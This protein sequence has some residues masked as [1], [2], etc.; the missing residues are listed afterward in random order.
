MSPEERAAIERRVRADCARICALESNYWAGVDDDRQ[1]IMDISIGA[2][3]A[4][5]NICAAMLRGVTVSQFEQEVE[6]RDS[7]EIP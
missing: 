4:A 7:K 6:V 2:M 3:G 1:H 5:A